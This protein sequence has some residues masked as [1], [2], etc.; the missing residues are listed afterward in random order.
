MSGL[1]A[2]VWVNSGLGLLA[3]LGTLFVIGKAFLA[4]RDHESRAMLLLAV[5]LALTLVAPVAVSLIWGLVVAPAI[6]EPNG[7]AELLF[8]IGES[9]L[10]VAGVGALVGS[11]YVRE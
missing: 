6:P 4:Y 2:L 5:G 9:L 7:Q 3:L 10:R 1:E 8:E 11:L